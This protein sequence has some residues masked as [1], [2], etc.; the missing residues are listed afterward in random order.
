M[1]AILLLATVVVAVNA[2]YTKCGPSPGPGFNGNTSSCVTCRTGYDNADEIR[3]DDP[4][5]R[6][7]GLT[8]FD[9]DDGSKSCMCQKHEC[10]DP[11][12][13]CPS[14]A[15]DGSTNTMA[16]FGLVFI[17]LLGLFVVY[18]MYQY[19]VDSEVSFPCCRVRTRRN[20]TTQIE[21]VNKPTSLFPPMD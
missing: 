1:R 3:C 7:E 11:C 18:W 2:A 6:S 8:C 20:P 12:P 17:V 15:F 13:K 16:W 19:F 21:M 4:D 14:R 9:E 5:C 10:D